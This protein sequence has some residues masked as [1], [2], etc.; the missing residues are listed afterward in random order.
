MAEF[1]SIKLADG[2]RVKDPYTSHVLTPG[3]IYKVGVGQF[4]LRRIE[5]GDVVLADAPAAP[6][7]HE[8]APKK[9][10]K[11]KLGD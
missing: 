7:A 2:R 3:K 5:S 11:E 4:W 6:I 1:M 8:P 10:K 9:S